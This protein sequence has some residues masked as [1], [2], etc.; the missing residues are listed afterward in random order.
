MT[1]YD[2]FLARYFYQYSISTT[3]ATE[4]DAFLR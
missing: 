2:Q 4:P 3:P 1:D